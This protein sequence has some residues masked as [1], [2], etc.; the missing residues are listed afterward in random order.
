[1]ILVAKRSEVRGV[2]I[3]SVDKRAVSGASWLVLVIPESHDC[4]RVGAFSVCLGRHI[5]QQALVAAIFFGKLC[6]LGGD[7]FKF[8]VK[9]VDGRLL[10][11]EVASDNELL[12]NQ[13]A[14]PAGASP[15]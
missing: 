12:R 5:L 11:S 8:I 4:L 13:V 15:F 9:L 7:C 10:F 1:M 14:D 2:A 6:H 3:R